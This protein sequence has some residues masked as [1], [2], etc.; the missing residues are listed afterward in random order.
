MAEI[1]SITYK[2]T[3]IGDSTVGKTCFFKKLTTG[4]YSNKNI[5]TVGIDRKTLSLKV[6][7]KENGEEIDKNFSIQIWDTAGQERFRAITRGYY[8]DSQGLIL[9]YDIT[10]KESF[11][12]IENWISNIKDLL[13]EE[14]KENNITGNKNKFLIIL[15][16]NK[17]D[18]D[19]IGLRKVPT[20]LAEEKCKE[21]NIFWGGE[22]SVKDSTMEEL[23]EKFKDFTREVYKL[24][25]N[26]VELRNTIRVVKSDHN[27]NE[28]KSSKCTC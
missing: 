2:F 5:S 20:E 14:E 15:L 23:I 1:D 9:M 10:N 8:K 21:M 27:K 3:I 13:G 4:K 28:N 12:N 11:D 25:G 6:K 17:V 19:E 22:C 16:G 7:V 24:I 18:L 26:N